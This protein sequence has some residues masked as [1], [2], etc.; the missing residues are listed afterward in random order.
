MSEIIAVE[1]KSKALKDIDGA[2][3]T[4]NDYFNLC[5]EEYLFYRRGFIYPEV[6]GSWVRGMNIYFKDDRIQELWLEEL[7]NES[8]YGLD[9][10]KEIKRFASKTKHNNSFNPTPQLRA[11]HDA[12]SDES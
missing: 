6:W 10:G 3:N 9:V 8:Y 5:G 1:S 7:R 11:S 2:F 4:L 12:S